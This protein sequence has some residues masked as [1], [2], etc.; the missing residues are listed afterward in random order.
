[1]AGKAGEMEFGGRD[2][3]TLGVGG[4]FGNIRFV[5][6]RM[7][8]AGM[9]GPLGASEEPESNKEIR[10]LMEETFL[11]ALDEV[12]MDLRMHRDM[13]DQ[14]IQLLLEK[15][16]LM[17]DEVEAFFDQYGLH[18]PKPQLEALPESTGQ[19]ASE[20]EEG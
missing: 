17:A 2:A 3:Q 8:N 5:L 15:E 9:F 1:V 11:T 20:E 19:V 4:D 12:R 7:A 16:E 6:G 10:E 13:G 18:T 14:L